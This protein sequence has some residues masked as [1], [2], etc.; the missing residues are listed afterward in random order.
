MDAT[1]SIPAWIVGVVIVAVWA[2][3]VWIVIDSRRDHKWNVEHG[4]MGREPAKWYQR[5]C[6]VMTGFTMIS[7]CVLRR[8]HEGEHDYR[9]MD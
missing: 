4:W 9:P 8:G 6:G 7:Y 3:L 1:V 2:F 5:K